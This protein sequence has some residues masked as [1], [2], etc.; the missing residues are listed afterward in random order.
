MTDLNTVREELDQ[1][2]ASLDD[3]RVAMREGDAVDLD[4][5]NLMV[6]KTC[7]AAVELPQADAPKVRP[8]LERL[9]S[10]LNEVKADIEAEQ[11]EINER[12]NDLSAAGEIDITGGQD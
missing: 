9:L 4:G 8:Q 1:A 7:K 11:T 12:L 2:V 5:F 3:L 6:A 10:G